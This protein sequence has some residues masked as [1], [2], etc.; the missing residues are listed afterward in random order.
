MSGL[1]A[2]DGADVDPAAVEQGLQAYVHRVASGLG[3]GA[4]AT[5]CEA[6]DDATAYIA[7]TERHPDWPD[8]DTA[9]IWDQEHGWVLAVETHSGED[10]LVLAYQGEALLPEP[11]TVITFAKQTFIEPALAAPQ[12]PRFAPVELAVWLLP[13]RPEPE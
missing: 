8:R 11:N 7:L 10:L 13:Y 2:L 5:F 3:L 6:A 1:D 9:L 12:P 4:V